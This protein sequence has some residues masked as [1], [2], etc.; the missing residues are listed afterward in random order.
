[1]KPLKIFAPAIVLL[2]SALPLATAQTYDAVRDF[3]LAA[4]PNGVWSYGS[5][6]KLGAPLTLYTVP[7]TNCFPGLTLSVWH[8]SGPCHT[9]YVNHNDSNQTICFETICVPPK[10]LLLDI[11][12]SGQGPFMTAVRWTAPQSGTFTIYGKVEGLDWAGPT[13]T[14][15]REVYNTNKQL[16]IR[17]IDTYGVPFSFQHTMLVNAGDT[18]DFIVDMGNDKSYCC[19][20]TGIQFVVNSSQ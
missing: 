15:F 4:N 17:V 8:G 6:T 7:D 18:I 13:T 3:S 16:L 19:D 10:Y 9:P 2:L 11:G 20:S 14:N 5:L 1:M 12:N